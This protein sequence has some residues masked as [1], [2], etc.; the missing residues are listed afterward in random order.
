MSRRRFRIGIA[1]AVS[2]ALLASGCTDSGEAPKTPVQPKISTPAETS[3]LVPPDTAT[4]P[5]AAITVIPTRQWDRIV[6]AG[7]WR[8][9]CP[10]GRRDLRRVEINHYT[11][12]GEIKRGALIVNKDIARSVVRIFTRLYEE[13]F[14]IR[15]MRP[16]EAYRG[17]V[18]AS[19]RDDN[20]SAHNCRRPS[21][22]N[23][24]TAEVA[25]P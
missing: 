10:V 12:D 24:P 13:E 11:F 3:S 9:G 18:K 23:A 15:K 19:L 22:I 7:V 5:D 25:A 17:D 2:S 1:V 8:P 4:G 6:S 14:P 20:T 16:V 21:Q